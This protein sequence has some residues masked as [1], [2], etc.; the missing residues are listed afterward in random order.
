M[1]QI[2]RWILTGFAGLS[3][4]FC[5]ETTIMWIR[6]YWSAD[7][8]LVTDYTPMDNG[9]T[10][11][12]AAPASVQQSTQICS[13]HGE[14]VVTKSLRQVTAQTDPVGRQWV[15]PTDTFDFGDS[16]LNHC[17]FGWANN[18]T[19]GFSS[20]NIFFPMWAIFLLTLLFPLRWFLN[21][22]R[23]AEH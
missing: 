1:K 12:N 3:L 13:T 20:A 11:P 7:A 21:R 17:G 18:Q 23:N 4:L 14:I 5:L 22:R 15:H 6:S 10:D 19:P 16:F 8:L 9:S 2:S